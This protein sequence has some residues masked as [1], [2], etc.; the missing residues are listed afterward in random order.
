VTHQNDPTETA[1]TAEQQT[2]LLTEAEHKAVADAGRLYTFIATE[3]IAD[4]PTRDEDLAELT[5]AIHVVQRMVMGNAAA[6][7]YPAKYRLL[8]QVIA[9]VD[10]ARK[11]A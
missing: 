7:A 1:A 4:G 6:R 2:P 11:P 8:G 5:A 10:A 9:P 3:V